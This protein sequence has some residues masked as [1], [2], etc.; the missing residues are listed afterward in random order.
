MNDNYFKK[1]VLY[2]VSYLPENVKPF[3]KNIGNNKDV[4]DKIKEHRQ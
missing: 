3:V 2:V 1:D 4:P